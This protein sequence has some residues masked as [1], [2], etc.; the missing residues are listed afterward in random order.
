MKRPAALL[1]G[2]A[3][4]LV[5]AAPVAAVPPTRGPAP[6][7][8][9]TFPAGIACPGF[10]VT[11]SAEVNKQTM[12]VFYDR[13][14]NPIRAT[15][16]GRLVMTFEG[17]GATLSLRLGDAIHLTFN[18]DGSLTVVGTGNVVY[19]SFPSD[20]PPGPSAT[21]YSGRLELSIAPDGTGTVVETA[22][23]SLDICAALG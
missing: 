23:K 2:A 5:F 21:L 19:I 1:A 15:V 6:I 8:P 13:D 12:T 17:N 14:G 9:V 4:A 22:G 11:V 16:V 18:P 3:A 10:A 7:D 20:V